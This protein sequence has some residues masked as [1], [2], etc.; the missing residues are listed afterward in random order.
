ML[1]PT[2]RKKGGVFGLLVT[3]MR[4]YVPGPQNIGGRTPAGVDLVLYWTASVDLGDTH[5]LPK[6]AL[7]VHLDML[8]RQT[9]LGGSTSVT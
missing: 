4:E 8:T 6:N 5:Q 9:Q 1:P 3:D 2:F 7:G